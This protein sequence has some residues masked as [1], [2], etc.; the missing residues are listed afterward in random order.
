[1]LRYQPLCTTPTVLLFYYYY[2]L[3]AEQ[4]DDVNGSSSLSYNPF[5]GSFVLDKKKKKM[6]TRERIDDE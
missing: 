6:E 3:V 5:V 1:M 4:C 2:Y